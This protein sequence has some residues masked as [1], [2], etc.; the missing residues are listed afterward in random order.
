MEEAIK[1]HV[2]DVRMAQVSNYRIENFVIDTTVRLSTLW[3]LF[4]RV[5]RT[6]FIGVVITEGFYSGFLW[7]A[8]VLKCRPFF[9]VRHKAHFRRICAGAKNYHHKRLH[10]AS[11]QESRHEI[12]AVLNRSDYYGHYSI[13]FVYFT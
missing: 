7:K 1:V 3:L 6:I 4:S 8:R 10:H 11:H 5:I 2:I 13:Y 9:V 12:E